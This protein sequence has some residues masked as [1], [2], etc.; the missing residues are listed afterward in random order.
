MNGITA[1]LPAAPTNPVSPAAVRLPVADGVHLNLQQWGEGS[2][3]VMCHG[4]LFGS[5]AAWY[6]STA[7]PLSARHQVV[8]YDMRGHGKSDWA[9]AGYGIN[10]QMQDLQQVISHAA[11]THD[12]NGHQEAGTAEEPVTLIGHSYGAMIALA[13]TLAHPERVRRLVLVDAPH[14]LSLHVRPGLDAVPDRDALMQRF[15]R[16]LA[17]PGRRA[18][19]LRQRLEFLLFE[20]TLRHDVQASADFSN[21]LLATLNTPTLCIYG[22]QSE[23][24]D[25]G[26]TLSHTLPNAALA[27]VN[28]GHYVTDDAPAEMLA[29][30]QTFIAD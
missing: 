18:E 13:Y 23:C 5:M 4:L 25:A 22:E 16:E 17:T 21:E 29:L 27:W 6:F 2:A 14:P 8:L 24:R 28:C 7:L 3:V 26:I 30:I 1:S 11:A 19:K 10:T 12:K 9:S 20:S 15:Q